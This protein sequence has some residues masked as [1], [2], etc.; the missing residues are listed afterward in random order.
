ME[1][2]AVMTE[3]ESETDGK[4]SYYVSFPSATN[5]QRQFNDGDPLVILFGWAG[6]QDRYLIKYSD[7]WL[8][9]G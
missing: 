4:S 2:I 3:E 7:V 9:Q 5:S 1:N 6:C 8:Q